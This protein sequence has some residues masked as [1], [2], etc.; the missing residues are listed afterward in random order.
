MNTNSK[1][2]NHVTH[3]HRKSPLP[4]L[5][6]RIILGRNLND[7]NRNTRNNE[8]CAYTQTKR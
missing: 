2:V 3:L 8:Y 5:E 1:V 6:T 7:I 4:P